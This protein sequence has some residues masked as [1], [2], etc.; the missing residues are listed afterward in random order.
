MLGIA[1]VSIVVSNATMNITIAMGT[2]GPQPVWLVAGE[3]VTA[4]HCR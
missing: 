3:L 1:T 2:S 4:A